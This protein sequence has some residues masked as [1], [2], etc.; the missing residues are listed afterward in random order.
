[1]IQVERTNWDD[2]NGMYIVFNETICYGYRWEC[3]YTAISVYIYL[4]K[5][6]THY[7]YIYIIMYIVYIYIHVYIKECNHMVKCLEQI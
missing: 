2:I 1:M 4:K 3:L 5:L 7:T 6:K